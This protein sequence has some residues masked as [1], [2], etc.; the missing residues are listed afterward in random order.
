MERTQPPRSS[1]WNDG[2]GQT[3][4]IA[5]CFGLPTGRLLRPLSLRLHA[6]YVQKLIIGL[7]YVCESHLT[8]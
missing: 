2:E 8:L 1:A 7:Y 6:N 4:A 3:P 5:K